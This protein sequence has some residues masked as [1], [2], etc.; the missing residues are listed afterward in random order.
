MSDENTSR[1]TFG[2][3][4]LLALVAAIGGA[5]F[6]A[7]I[8][9]GTGDLTSPMTTAGDLIVGGDA[10]APTRLPAGSAGYIMRT[11]SGAPAWRELSAYGALADRPACAAGREGQHYW[12]T[13]GATGLQ[14]TLCVHHGAA[15]FEWTAVAYD[16]TAAGS[17]IART[18]TSSAPDGGVLTIANGSPTW[19]AASAGESYP[20]ELLTGHE[21]D[22]TSAGATPAGSTASIASSQV[23]VTQAASSAC[24]IVSGPCATDAIRAYRTLNAPT[25][26]AWSLR[27]RLVSVDAYGLWQPALGVVAGT[28]WAT[29]APKYALYFVSG[30]D[31]L[32]FYRWGAGG[33]SAGAAVITNLRAGQGWVRIDGL[34]RTL[35]AYGG[36]GSGG[37]EPTSWT[38][39]GTFTLTTAEPQ[40]QRVVAFST[41]STGGSARTVVWDSVRL[42]AV[43]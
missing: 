8:G 37:A 28:T 3:A 35:T 39:I 29:S 27:A 13:D 15:T 7:A 43:Q 1:K 42:Q 5:A 9:A 14:H 33:S 16:V 2:T 31:T 6:R 18:D 30:S 34:G 26:A 24:D 36:V 11:V 10:G 23:T 19:A 12:V 41:G 4:A 38:P 20:V 17:A 32:I 21:A 40:P 25:L 22:W